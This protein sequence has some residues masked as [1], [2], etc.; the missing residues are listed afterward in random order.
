MGKPIVVMIH[1]LVGSLYY[2][3]PRERI[4][5]AIVDTP[6]L[7]GYGRFRNAAATHL[8]IAEQAEHVVRSIDGRWAEPVWLLGHSMGG[9]V[10]M[11][12]A[13]R[14]PDLIVAMINVEGNFTEKDAFWSRKIAALTAEEWA[15]EYSS[16]CDDIPSCLG[17][18]RIDK[19][20]QR[21]DWLEHIL[22][23]QPSGTVHAMATALVRETLA[24]EYMATVETVVARTPV[25]LVAGERSTGGWGI[26]DSVRVAA[27]SYRVQANA[28][29]LMMLEYPSEFCRLVSAVMQLQ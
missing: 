26:P 5:G 10:A 14:R 12:V 24:D 29:H 23:N 13:Y 21:C 9:A 8:S 27:A 6:D 17:K 4:S 25:H 1:G 20:E 22:F 3:D 2:F 16:M 7:L 19:T 11:E 15:E 28:G 18:W